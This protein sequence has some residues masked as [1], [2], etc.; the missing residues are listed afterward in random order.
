MLTVVRCK[1]SGVAEVVYCTTPNLEAMI[2]HELRKPKGLIYASNLTG[3]KKLDSTGS[4]NPLEV[5]RLRRMLRYQQALV[6]V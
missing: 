6:T 2:I 3:L 4:L 5:R 1:K